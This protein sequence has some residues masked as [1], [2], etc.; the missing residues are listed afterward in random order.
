MPL[1]H[2]VIVVPGITAIE[3]TDV[4]PRDRDVIW[5]MVLN[6]DYRRIAL[7]PQ[8]LR[9]E[10]VEPSR[11]VPGQPFS[12]YE[13]LVAALRHELSPREDEP[14]PVFAFPYDWRVDVRATAAALGRFIEE[15]LARTRLLKHYAGT[16]AQLRVDLVGHS[17]GGLVITQY[18]ADAR[19]K[20]RV[21]KVV[22]LGTPFLGAAEAIAKISTGLSRLTV[23]VPK[24]RERET[25][26]L[27]PSVYQLLPSYPGAI[28]DAAGVDRDVFD[29]ENFQDTIA[30]SIAEFIRLYGTLPRPSERAWEI[31]GELLEGA[32]AHRR[33]V[34]RFKPG[35]A[36]LTQKDW[37][38]VVGVGQ[39]TRLGVGFDRHDRKEWFVL[40]EALVLNE[41]SSA[42]PTSRR[43]G[44]GTVPLFGALAPFL[45]ESQLVCV[46]EEDFGF[47]EMRDRLLAEVGGFHGLLPAINLVQNLVVRHL[48]PGFRGPV[49][50]RR[51]PGAASWR[52]P[53]E[54]L[55][56]RAY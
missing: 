9:Y 35:D 31:V 51:V 14:T 16:E 45:P 17:M 37:L 12:I 6:K 25:A 32:A 39:K 24:A 30:E 13:D 53:I 27:T 49:H 22:T 50:G 18:L 26:R 20:A 48:R 41:L 55:Q 54:K 19:R 3:L 44:D 23:A 10:A 8:D 21:G 7:H 36:G 33:T 29:R 34:E 2:P 5:S 56:E 43:T 40:D 52:P 11:V 46:T 15:V 38:A 42:H 47:W 1:Q 28:R 4:Y